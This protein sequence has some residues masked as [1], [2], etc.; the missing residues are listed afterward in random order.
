MK[1]ISILHLHTKISSN[2]PKDS[3]Y[4]VC[5]HWQYLKQLFYATELAHASAVP[6][7]CPFQMTYLN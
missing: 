4:P 5:M 6:R 1:L 2:N 7:E 3:F